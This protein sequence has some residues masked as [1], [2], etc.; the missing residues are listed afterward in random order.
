MSSLGREGPLF[1]LKK[2]LSCLLTLAGP[3]FE[4]LHHLS[5]KT[6]CL[7]LMDKIPEGSTITSE[8]VN[9]QEGTTQECYENPSVISCVGPRIPKRSM[10]T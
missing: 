9:K 8:S 7:V 1:Y 10:A 5:S 3:H 6:G 2:Y 4:Q